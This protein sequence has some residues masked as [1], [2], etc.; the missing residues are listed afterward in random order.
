MV[1]G[2]NALF[3]H[4]KDGMEDL[5]LVIWHLG[6]VCQRARLLGRLHPLLRTLGVAVP[7]SVR[8]REA[9]SG[10]DCGRIVW[11]RLDGRGRSSKKR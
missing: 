5:Y 1:L 7:I 2:T 8:K 11:R 4:T 9:D 3:I 10:N 6:Y